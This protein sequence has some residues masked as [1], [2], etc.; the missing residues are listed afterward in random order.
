MKT[1]IKHAEIYT[2][3]WENTVAEALVMENGRILQTGTEDK[4]QRIYGKRMEEVDCGGR[5]ILPAFHDSHMHLLGYGLFL[6]M[7][8]LSGV[9]SIEEL[10]YRLRQFLGKYGRRKEEWIRGR[11]WNQDYFREGRMPSKADLDAVSTEYP[12]VISR[13]CGHV[14]VANSKAMEICNIIKD[15]KLSAGA[16]EVWN[17]EEQKKES[18]LEMIGIGED[19]LPNGVFRESGMDLIYRQILDPDLETIKECLLKGQ[20]QLLSQGI[21]AV[22]SDDFGNVSDYKKVIQAFLELERE[23]R[24]QIK[25]YEQCNFGTLSCWKEFLEEE[26]SLFGRKSDW[27]IDRNRTKIKA[28]SQGYFRLG[29]LKIVGDGS[30]GARTAWLRN[31]Y[32]DASDTKG[33]AYYK[34]EE[35]YQYMSYTHNNGIPIAIH[36]IGDAMVEMAV[37]CFERLQKEY[38]RADLRHGIVHCQITDDQLLRRIA[39][40]KLMVFIQPIFLNYDLHIVEKRVGKELAQTSYNWKSLLKYGGLLSIGSDC[41]VETFDPMKNIYSAVTRKD[42]KGYPEQGFYPEQ[43][44]SVQEAVS[45]YTRGSVYAVYQE[46]QQGSLEAGKYADMVVLDQNIFQCKAQEIKDISIWKT[47]AGGKEI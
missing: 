18:L 19:G 24:L 44:L 16:E 43:R 38:P 20:K 6:N 34:K 10:Q 29:C 7:V 13:V 30:L 26:G 1:L 11:G 41:P 22:Q 9:K 37:D 32:Q 21:T 42:L 47:F 17:R 4:L 35:L 14:L 27:E 25:V 23:G 46:K 12:I 8:D 3:D 28:E 36:G 5:C 31:P 45:A 15:G 2:L 40:Q 39:K 33:I